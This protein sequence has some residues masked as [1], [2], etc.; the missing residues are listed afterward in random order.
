[1]LLPPLRL[2]RARP[3]VRRNCSVVIMV[4]VRSL[5]AASVYSSGHCRFPPFWASTEFIA[6]R[7]PHI[8]CAFCVR[9]P[10]FHDASSLMFGLRRFCYA[11]FL[12]PTLWHISLKFVVI[13]FD[14]HCFI[15]SA[16]FLCIAIVVV[17]ILLLARC[18]HLFANCCRLKCHFAI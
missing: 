5:A 1:M 10:F 3:S 4:A 12:L 11:L 13:V 16:V 2:L 6:F 9:V 14:F 15:F 8:I 7:L 17:L 18:C